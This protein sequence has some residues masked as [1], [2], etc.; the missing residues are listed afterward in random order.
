MERLPK[1]A[2]GRA[3]A[4]AM[5][6]NTQCQNPQAVDQCELIAGRFTVMPQDRAISLPAFICQV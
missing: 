3:K 4:S 2:T 5:Y 6:E 1:K